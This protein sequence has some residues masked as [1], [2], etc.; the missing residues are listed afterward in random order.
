VRGSENATTTAAMQITTAN[1]TSENPL[2]I[3]H[4][5]GGAAR[6]PAPENIGETPE[7]APFA[8]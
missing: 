2:A 7:N 5:W 6:A 3:H 1:S 4:L 8:G